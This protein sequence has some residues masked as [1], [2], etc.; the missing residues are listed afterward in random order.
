VKF[1]HEDVHVLETYQQNSQIQ[2]CTKPRVFIGI[3]FPF[4]ARLG[5]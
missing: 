3:V 4:E 2:T 5:T 1:A